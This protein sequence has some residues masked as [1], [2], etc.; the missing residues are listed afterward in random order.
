LT[1]TTYY[2]DTDGDNYGDINDTGT[3]FCASPGPGYVTNNTDCNDGSSAIN[4]GA[5]EVCDGVD[6]NCNTLIDEGLTF[7]TYYVDTDGDNYGDI[8]DTG[9]SFCASPGPGYVTNNTDCNDTDGA[10]NPGATEVCDG[11]DNNCNSLIDDGLTFTNYYVDGDGDGFGAGAA[12]SFC[13]NPGAGYVTNNTDCNDGDGAINPGA[14]EV[15]DGIDNNCNSLIDDG[16]TF[17]NYYVDGDG[18]GFGAGAAQSFC[19]NPGAGYVTNNTDCND[20][21]GAINPGATEVCDGI[22]NNCNSLIDDGLTFTNYYVDGDGDGYGAGAAQSLCVNPGAGYATNNTDCNDTDGAINP[23]ATEVC[24]GVDNNCNSLVDDGLT[25][26]NYYVD[27]DGDGFGAGAAQS[28]CANPGAGYS[29]NNTDCDDN[30]NTTYPGAP[31]LCDGVD[32]DCNSIIDDNITYTT[33]YV[34]GDTDG[35]G[36]INDAGTSLCTNPG[37]GYSTNNTDCNDADGAINPGAT[38][39]CDGVD[40]NCNSL[41]DDG[42]TFTTYYV[43]GDTDG[44]GDINDAGTSLCTNPGAGYST[45]NTDCNDADG[46]INPGATEVC[47]GV[48][49]NCNSLIDDGL[50]FTTYY[51][52]SD[53]DSY[54]DGSLPGISLC[55]NPGAGYSTNST[56]CNDAN[57]SINPGATEICDSLDNDCNFLIDDGLTFTDYYVDGDDDGYGDENDP[58]VSLCANPGSGY[59]TTNDDCDDTDNSVYPGATEIIGNGIDENCDGVD[60]Y[61]DLKEDGF[62]SFVLFPNPSSSIVTITGEKFDRVTVSDLAGKTMLEFRSVNNTELHIDIETLTNGVYL[63]HIKSELK[64][65]TIRFIKQ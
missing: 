32:N 50:T 58:G 21:D 4:P 48:D 57:S 65:E 49:N 1:F 11:V 3:S 5:T 36:D 14:T 17:T 47:D 7:T 26:T 64:L 34:D 63:V 61:L 24:D 23:G 28:L 56:D 53:G 33:Y 29:T 8:N 46:A 19:A 43:D 10:I 62:S 40:N 59:S 41:I 25:F 12:Q 37:A 13:A 55:A 31:E 38:E 54:G 18:D 15:C 44:Y 45:N 39:V 35:Y 27:G 60:G 20:G 30:E 51:V 42:L 2:V 9:T 6:N 16:L 52:D 22:D